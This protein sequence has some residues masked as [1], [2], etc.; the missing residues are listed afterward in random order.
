[1][2]MID[3]QEF[4]DELKLRENI[5][6]VIKLVVE[7]RKRQDEEQL[8]EEQRLRKVIRN[9]ILSEASGVSDEV[10]HSSTGINVLRDLLKKIIPQMEIHYK[11]LTTNSEQ[12][13]SFRAHVL[14]ALQNI[15]APSQAIQAI[16][17]QEDIEISFDDDEDA[18]PDLGDEAFIDIEDAPSAEEE[19]EDS[20]TIPGEEMTG[21]NK[22]EQFIDKIESQTQSE[23]ESLGSDGDRE[24][25]YDYL[26]TNVKLYFDKFED[27]LA[28]SLEEPTTPEYEETTAATDEPAAEEEETLDLE[29]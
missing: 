4:A 9:I 6:K 24:E 1:M 5:R 22:A 7:K 28:A 13:D 16:Q 25:F 11:Q 12:R 14:K 17:E 23:Y 19:E 26:L 20:F 18:L 27:E 8:L 15:L 3:R 10:P 29:I 21:R 2:I